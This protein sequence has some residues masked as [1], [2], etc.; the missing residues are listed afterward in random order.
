MRS[1]LDDLTVAKATSM[2][3]RS[4]ALLERVRAMPPIT[5]PG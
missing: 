1:D 3:V 4:I 5:T 2:I